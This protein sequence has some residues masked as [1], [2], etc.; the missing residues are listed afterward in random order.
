MLL[1]NEFIS[2]I[3]GKYKIHRVFDGKDIDFGTFNTL[4]EAI[5]YR[6]ELDDDGWP[7]P[8]SESE[9]YSF[10]EKYI[11]KL[12]ENKFIVFNEINN[13]EKTF[14]PYNSI[15]MAKI[16]RRNLLSNGWESDLEFSRAKYTKY[17]RK[18]GMSGISSKYIFI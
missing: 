7:I 15:E 6:D 10:S 18:E 9:D 12:S 4:D 13:K 11:K 8:L 14:G 1:N 2:K 16:A 17:I 5:K 3:D